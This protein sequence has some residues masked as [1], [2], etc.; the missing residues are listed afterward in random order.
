MII[1]ERDIRNQSVLEAAHQIMVAAVQH[2][3]KR[4]RYNRANYRNRRRH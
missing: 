4:N 3:R 1:N 2:I